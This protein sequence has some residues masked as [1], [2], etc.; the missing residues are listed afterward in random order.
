MTVKRIL[1]ITAVIGFLILIAVI[2]LA[3][4]SRNT[5]VVRVIKEWG[6]S[7]VNISTERLVSLQGHPYWGQTGGGFDKFFGQPQSIAIGTMKLNGIGSGVVI[8]KDGLVVTNAHVVNMARRVY[9]IFA[10]G[11]AVPAA[12]AAINPSMD[13][14]IIKIS[15]PKKL[16]PIRLAKNI[17]IG[18]TVISI[19]NPLGLQNSVSAGIVSATNRSFSTPGAPASLTGLIQ[20]DASINE[21]SSGG[22]ILNLKGELVGISLALV[23]GAQSIGFAIPAEKVRII[24]SDY[25]EAMAKRASVK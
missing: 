8:S 5:P 23:Q 20:T 22:A 13:L 16:K 10:D 21:G 9:V 18:E 11:T 7:V 25:R 6:P 24:L 12:L 1:I 4:G 17:V 2:F 15:P 19:G 3:Q 14:A